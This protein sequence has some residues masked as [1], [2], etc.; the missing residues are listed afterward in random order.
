MADVCQICGKAIAGRPAYRDCRDAG[1]D[2]SPDRWVHI[3]CVYEQSQLK[4]MECSL[5]VDP[6]PRM[7]FRTR[8]IDIYPR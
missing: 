7:P 5:P 3:G 6:D 1:Q 4:P 2:E 8:V